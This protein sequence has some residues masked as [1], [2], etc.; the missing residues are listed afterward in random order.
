MYGVH[1]CVGCMVLLFLKIIINCRFLFLCLH[2]LKEVSYISFKWLWLPTVW[3]WLEGTILNLFS[4]EY[5]CP[6]S[7]TWLQGAILY[8]YSVTLIAHSLN[9]ATGCCLIPLFSGFDCPQSRTWLE[10]AF[11]IFFYLHISVTL[12]TQ[13]LTWLEDTL[14][15]LISIINDYDCLKALFIPHFSDHDCPHQ[16]GTC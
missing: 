10:G 2:D 14:L 1:A 12:P 16:Y 4:S 5:D 7:G 3:T 9:L 6:Q 13:S 8:L 11:I 15:H